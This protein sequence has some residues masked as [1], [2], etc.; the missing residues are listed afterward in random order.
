MLASSPLFSG[1]LE[2][3][4]A[5]FMVFALGVPSTD[6]AIAEGDSWRGA[7]FMEGDNALLSMNRVRDGLRQRRTQRLFTAFRC[8]FVTKTAQHELCFFSKGDNARRAEV[9]E[10]TCTLFRF[11]RT[12]TVRAAR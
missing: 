11:I 2:A 6:K 10:Q 8:T 12:M 7:S 3:D 1:R 4:R 9:V 5:P